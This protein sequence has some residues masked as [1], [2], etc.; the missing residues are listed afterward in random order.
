M[1]ELLL[2]CGKKQVFAQGLGIEKEWQNVT[3][4]DIDEDCKPDIVQD[5]NNIPLPFDDNTF[6]EVHAYE[7]LE[8]LGTQGDWKFFFD[9]FAEFHRV[10]KDG[11]Y[12]CGT[13]PAWDSAWAWGDP[14][15]TRIINEGTLVFLCQREYEMQVSKTSMTDYRFYWKKNFELIA[16]KY[17]DEGF[18]FVLKCTK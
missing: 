8:H 16:N 13:V 5:L 14:G 17:E 4:I 9:Q 10:M 3:K 1:R 11:A 7:V 15:H 18:A 12:F 6:D 2:G